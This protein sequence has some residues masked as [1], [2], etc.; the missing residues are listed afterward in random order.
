MTITLQALSWVKR[1]SRSKFTPDYAWRAKKVYECK[2]DVKST[3]IPMTSNGS[4]LM[5]IWTIFKNHILELDLT[6]NRETM[7]ET[8]NAHKCWFILLYHMWGPPWIEIHWHNIWLRARSHMALHYTW[9]SVTTQHGHGS[10]LVCEVALT[11]SYVSNPRWS[12]ASQKEV[13]IS[14]PIYVK[15]M[16]V[17]CSK[18]PCQ[19]CARWN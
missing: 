8:P 2:M 12:G 17:P 11:Q 4:C 5:I 18:G 13:T 7:H 15:L 9:G 3:W 6:Q 19:P 14:K 10:W 1:R 16:G